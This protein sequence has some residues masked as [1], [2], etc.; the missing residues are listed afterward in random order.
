[1]NSRTGIDNGRAAGKRGQR[2]R[3][4]WEALGPVGAVAGVERDASARLVDLHAIA[5]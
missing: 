4:T 1:M 2:C 3:E 5:V